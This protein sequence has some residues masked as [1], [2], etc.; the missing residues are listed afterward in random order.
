M[1]PVP[2][3][4]ARAIGRAACAQRVAIVYVDRDGNFGIT[5]WGLTRADCRALA[6]WAESDAAV[7][8]AQQV[9]GA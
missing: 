1:K 4:Q 8:V 3:L 2:V 7:A 6:A 5:T 9:K